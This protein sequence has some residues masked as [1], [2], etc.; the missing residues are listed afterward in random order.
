MPHARYEYTSSDEILTKCKFRLQLAG[1]TTHD[2]ELRLSMSAALGE[3]PSRDMVEEKWVRDI[4]I[5]EA[6]HKMIELPCGFV[7]FNEP[8]CIL[9]KDVA[10]HCTYPRVRPGTVH[11]GKNWWRG[12]DIQIS[13]GYIIFD[14]ETTAVT[15]DIY[16]LFVKLDEQTG[17]LVIPVSHTE[18]IIS[19]MMF[20]YYETRGDRRAQ[21]HYARWGRGKKSVKSKTN[22]P[23]VPDNQEIF[24]IRNSL[25]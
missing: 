9:M 16:A 21:F 23:D 6:P 25:N 15:V 5:C 18:A 12:C 7:R 22:N 2:A 14:S 17:K 11:G 8:N 13:N 19:F 10:G 1:V 4:P 20:Q 3:L 24:I